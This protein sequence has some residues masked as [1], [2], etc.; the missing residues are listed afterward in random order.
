MKRHFEIHSRLTYLGLVIE[1][2]AFAFGFGAVGASIF[3]LFITESSLY[4]YMGLLASIWLAYI[5]FTRPIHELLGIGRT[6]PIEL[7]K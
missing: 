1:R 5:G 4:A 6:D 7:Q 2:C 3:N